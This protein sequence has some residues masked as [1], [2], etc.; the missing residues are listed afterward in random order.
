[1]AA[2]VQY[3]KGNKTHRFA[4]N[5]HQR[6]SANYG[7]GQFTSKFRAGGPGPFLAQNTLFTD[8]YHNKAYRGKFYDLTLTESEIHSKVHRDRSNLRDQNQVFIEEGIKKNLERYDQTLRD[9]LNR[10]SILKDNS[11]FP[12][13]ITS[14]NAMQPSVVGTNSVVTANTNYNG[15]DVSQ[16]QESFDGGSMD[17]AASAPNQSVLKHAI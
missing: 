1:M 7:L 10:S 9:K 8:G 2:P 15:F 11:R 12:T 13:L 17:L 6:E 14:I 4:S 16:L 5:P 3:V